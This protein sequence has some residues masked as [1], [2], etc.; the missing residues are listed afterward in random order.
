MLKI[1]ARSTPLSRAQF[2]EVSREILARDPSLV[3]EPVWASSPGDRDKSTSLRGLE[4]TDFF[5]RDLDEMLLR[6][7]IDLAIHSAKDLPDPLPKGLVLIA[8]TQGLDPRDSLVLREGL[9]LETMPKNAVIATSSARREV[10]A[11]AL[12]PTFRFVDLRGSIAERLAKLFSGEVDGVIVAEAALIRL[13]KTHL[14]RVFLPGD[15]TPL[16]GKL[17]IVGR[18]GDSTPFCNRLNL[19]L[20]KFL[21]M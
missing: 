1:G 11:R 13:K 17:A 2:E 14:N 3:L 19:F 16:Q 4:K 15:T 6:G 18:S 7:D 10:A 20:S 12:C 8:L 9:S 21:S 5:T